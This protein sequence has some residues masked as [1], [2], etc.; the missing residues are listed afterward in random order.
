MIV[1][2]EFIYARD[3]KNG[4][5]KNGNMPWNCP[6]DLKRFAKITKENCKAKKR[7]PK[8]AVLMGRKTWDSLNKKFKPLPNRTNIIL[9]RSTKTH[10]GDDEKEIIY[11]SQSPEDCKSFLNRNCFTKVFVIGG[12]EI[13]KL[14]EKQ[15]S[16][17]HESHIFG[18]FD[19][20]ITFSFDL[21]G[22]SPEVVEEL[23]DHKYTL[24]RKN[25]SL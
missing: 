4:I 7:I 20:D 1:K 10:Y 3:D 8:A 9:S 11:F 6:K 17:V 19:C 12:A 2:I 22:F 23:D 13:F 24:W 15:V 14:F 16:V 18:D 21:K 25:D 5:A